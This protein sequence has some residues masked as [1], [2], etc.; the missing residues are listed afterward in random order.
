MKD[1][2]TAF[3]TRI[4]E[5]RNAAG[6]SQEELADRADVHW[7]YLSD[8]ERGRQ[9]PTLDVVNRVAK[10]LRVTIASL[11]APFDEPYRARARKRRSDA[12]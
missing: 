8:L 3:G 7:T 5:L 11:F 2:R 4:R 6:L 10:A 12:Q 1:L 9:S